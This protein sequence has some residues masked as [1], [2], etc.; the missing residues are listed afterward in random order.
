MRRVFLPFPLCI[1]FILSL[2]PFSS[3]PLPF[4]LFPPPLLSCLSM[5]GL[6]VRDIILF[7][8]EFDP[9]ELVK[10]FAIPSERDEW[11]AVFTGEEFKT[12]WYTERVARQWQMMFESG[13]RHIPLK[14]ENVD[15]LLPIHTRTPVLLVDHHRMIGAFG[16]AADD[17]VLLLNW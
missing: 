12:F 4:L 16:F 9:R 3:S 17:T 8:D 6:R 7:T 13:F 14:K 2:P 15:D 10:P 1:H 5:T 11:I